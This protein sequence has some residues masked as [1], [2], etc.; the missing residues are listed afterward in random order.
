M[1]KLAVLLLTLCLFITAS[2]TSFA[3]IQ[4]SYKNPSK[5]KLQNEC[6]S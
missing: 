4:S 6:I 1:K 2:I 3:A 5:V